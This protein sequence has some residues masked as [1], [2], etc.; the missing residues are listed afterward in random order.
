MTFLKKSF[1]QY[2]DLKFSKTQNMTINFEKYC[3]G[4]NF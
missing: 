1:M 2:Y 3:Y 4:N